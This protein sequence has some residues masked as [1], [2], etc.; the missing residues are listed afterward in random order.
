MQ[1]IS[2]PTVR[3]LTLGTRGP[4]ARGLPTPNVVSRVLNEA[5]P[6]ILAIVDQAVIEV[7]FANLDE[8]NNG[9][10]HIGNDNN[11]GPIRVEGRGANNTFA[12][13][14]TYIKTRLKQALECHMMINRNR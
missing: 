3:P 10:G 1:N 12:D 4:V 5:I 7:F 6:D 11:H 9:E 2:P 8:V 14:K 13:I